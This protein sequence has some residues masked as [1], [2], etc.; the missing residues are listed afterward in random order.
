METKLK[1]G[2]KVNI[3]GM[4]HL[5]IGRTKMI[6]S[7]GE[8][9]VT[10]KDG[11]EDVF[12][13]YQISICEQVITVGMG[14]TRCYYTDAHAYTIIKISKS[15]RKITMQ[16]D[17]ATLMNGKKLEFAV[18]GFAAHCSNQE[19]QEYKYE[20]NPNGVVVE[21]RLTKMGWKTKGGAERVIIGSR[22]EFY[23]YNF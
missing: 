15:G 8:W 14:A 23:D 9:V 13:M 20:A 3:K 12:N 11:F 7:S 22:S 19:C 21:A 1:A 18:G 6:C 2:L 10:F 4:E 16:R 5:G 17:T